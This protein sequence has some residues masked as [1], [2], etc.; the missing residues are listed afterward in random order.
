M[1]YGKSCRMYRNSPLALLFEAAAGTK[2]RKHKK[3]RT[4]IIDIREC[5][6]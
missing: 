6:Y 4:E 5:K 2:E 1:N 3:K